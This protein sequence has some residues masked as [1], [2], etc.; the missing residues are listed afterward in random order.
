MG[1]RAILA[2]DLLEHGE[3]ADVAQPG[4]PE[5][6]DDYDDIWNPKP[7]HDDE[8]RVSAAAS[9]KLARARAALAKA[10]AVVAAPTRRVLTDSDGIVIG[11]QE[12]RVDRRGSFYEPD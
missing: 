5:V 11:A 2:L 12:Q 10:E 9:D 4:T 3:P 6:S 1:R 8:P 7:L